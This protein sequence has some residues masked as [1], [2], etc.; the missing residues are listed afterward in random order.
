VDRPLPALPWCFAAQ[1]DEKSERYMFGAHI[2]VNTPTGRPRANVR[3]EQ[4]ELRQTGQVRC[5][6]SQ[7]PCPQPHSDDVF[8]ACSLC[9]SVLTS[10]FFGVFVAQAF[11]LGRYTVH[12]HMHRDLA[13][14]SYLRGCAIHHTY[15]RACTI[16]GSHRVILQ[17][18]VAYWNMG[19]A[20]FLEV[21][22]S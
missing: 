2:L 1:G 14:Q 20:F 8:P 19:H 17:D 21:R 15:N 5:G 6:C 13:F 18:N 10:L 22:R 7:K 11:R 16:H 3:L 12:F 4:V 9:G